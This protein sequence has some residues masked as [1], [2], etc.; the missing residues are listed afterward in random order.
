MTEDLDHDDLDT[1]P[2]EDIPE[3]AGALQ[4]GYV[5]GEDGTIGVL[6]D[7]ELQREIEVSE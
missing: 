2:P 1:I 7:S 6:D 5:V 3:D 4:C